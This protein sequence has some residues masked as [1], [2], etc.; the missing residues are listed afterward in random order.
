MWFPEGL[1]NTPFTKALLFE[2][3]KSLCHCGL[4]TKSYK[5]IASYLIMRDKVDFLKTSALYS[6]SI[7]PLYVLHSRF[8]TKKL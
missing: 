2:K 7:E 4:S 6:E 5:V 1:E 8:P 3:R